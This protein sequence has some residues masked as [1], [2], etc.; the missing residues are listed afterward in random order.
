MSYSQSLYDARTGQTSQQ[1]SQNASAMAPPVD[2]SDIVSLL[3][4]GDSAAIA[5]A[6]TSTTSSSRTV[7]QE[8][9]PTTGPKKEQEQ[10]KKGTARRH[11][12][13]IAKQILVGSGL[14]VSL[15]HAVI[16]ILKIF[17]ELGQHCNSSK[18]IAKGYFTTVQTTG[19]CGN[20]NTGKQH[21]RGEPSPAHIPRQIN[22]H[23]AYSLSDGY[24]VC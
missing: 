8:P 2:Y 18:N 22:Q 1:N 5:Q 16:P 4:A 14:L 7:A 24:W 12:L 21:L 23:L 11:V 6:L 19:Q 9:T 13:G 15:D 20:T 3:E 17:Q 10:E